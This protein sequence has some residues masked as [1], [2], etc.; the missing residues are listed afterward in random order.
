ML[1]AELL[2]HLVRQIAG[3]PLVEARA[4]RQALQA[5]FLHVLRDDRRNPIRPSRGNL[6]GPEKYRIAVKQATD[7]RRPLPS[8][9]VEGRR[10]R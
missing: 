2:G 8:E 1:A 10:R 6:L 3:Q 5:P 9:S 7:G 4:G